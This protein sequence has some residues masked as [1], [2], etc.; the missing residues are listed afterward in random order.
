MT[1]NTT[2]SNP[3]GTANERNRSSSKR[4]SVD[5]AADK[6]RSTTQQVSSQAKE[7]ARGAYERGKHSA[8]TELEN[9]ASALREVAQSM[10]QKEGA[11][12]SRLMRTAAEKL[13]G[14]SA[15]IDQ[16]NLDDVVGDVERLA[17]RNPAVFIGSAIALGFIASRFLKASRPSHDISSDEND[18][19]I[20]SPGIGSMPS[21]TVASDRP[22]SSTGLGYEEGL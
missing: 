13:E 5:T 4:A 9:I 3:S 15:T 19:E 14:L 12:S 11:S 7:S 16:K 21:S 10:Q 20:V 17:R 1:P 8:L 22:M 18:F 6:V 2:G